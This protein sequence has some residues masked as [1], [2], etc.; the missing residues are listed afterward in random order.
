MPSAKSATLRQGCRDGRDERSVQMAE[1][2]TTPQV[3]H[4]GSL[5]AGV[6]VGAFT[7]QRTTLQLFYD[8]WKEYMDTVKTAIVPLTDEQLA[9]RAAP[10]E[11][12]V[13]EIVQHIVEARVDWF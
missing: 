3:F 12:S 7:E 4:D 6:I 9:L 8:G 5:A 1:Q 10:H 11:R 13:G 2:R